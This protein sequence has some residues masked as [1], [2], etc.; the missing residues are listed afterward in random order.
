MK[1][2][3]GRVL[4]RE[5]I[6][7][8]LT[9]RIPRRLVTQF[10]GWWS[11]IEQPVIRDLSLLT[12]RLFADDLGLHEAKKKRF[13]SLHDC[14]VRELKEGARPIDMDRRI[15]VSPCDGVIGASGRIR[16]TELIQA[17]G[18]TYDL[19]DLLHDPALVESYTD[20]LYVTLRLKANMYHRFH[21]VHDCRIR[22]VTYIS[23]DTFNVNPIATRR[24]EN[25]FCK[26]ERVVL[27]GEL[28]SGHVVTLVA[29]AAVLV[30]SVRLPFL[31]ALL[32]LKYRGPNVIDCDASFRKGQEL[33]WFQ[34]GSTIIVFAPKGVELCENVVE[35]KTIRMGQ[36]LLRLP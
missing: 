8:V 27:S 28:H 4:Q 1:A 26:N 36:P 5:R 10:V 16:G 6:N 35:G 7:F 29:V 24:I 9:N 18:F 15:A 34:H 25:L 21:A 12:F 33:G 30:A 17:K 32:H 2:A 13:V 14:F 19:C 11:Q 31:G 23:G 3:I 20:G 22:R